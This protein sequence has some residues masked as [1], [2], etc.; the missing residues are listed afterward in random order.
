[1]KRILSNIIFISVTAGT[2]YLFFFRKAWL[3]QKIKSLTGFDPIQH[4]GTPMGF[5]NNNP[6]NIRSVEANHWQGEITSKAD[7]KGFEVFD[8]MDHGIRA[9]FIILKKKWNGG[10]TTIMDII[11]GKKV[12]GK[13]V[14]GWAPESENDV[15]SYCKLV[16]MSFHN[17]FPSWKSHSVDHSLDQSELV[18]LAWAMSNV[19]IGDK[20]APKLEIFERVNSQFNLI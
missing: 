17:A 12:D 1:M 8:T 15:A 6:L 3:Q 14:G 2:L 4:M 10:Q 19:E 5:T 18:F 13:Y 11:A 16:L 20:Y 7:G 9:A